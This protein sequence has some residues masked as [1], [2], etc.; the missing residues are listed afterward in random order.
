MAT[1]NNR[2]P[3]SAHEGVLGCVAVPTAALSL[4]TPNLGTANVANVLLTAVATTGTHVARA[5]AVVIASTTLAAHLR[6]WHCDTTALGAY[7]GNETHFQIVCEQIG[8][9]HV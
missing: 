5:E 9:A 3:V 1:S 4:T 8:R 7:A 2:D 6:F